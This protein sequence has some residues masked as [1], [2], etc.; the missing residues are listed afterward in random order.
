[1]YSIIMILKC[2]RCKYVWD[3]KGK[4]KWYTSCPRCKTTI[5]TIKNGKN[6]L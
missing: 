1:M 6:K 2:K 3:Y 5:K 4:S